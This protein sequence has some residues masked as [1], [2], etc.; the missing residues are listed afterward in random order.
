[1]NIFTLQF[2]KKRANNLFLSLS[3]EDSLEDCSDPNSHLNIN[4][5]PGQDLDT[6][7]TLDL[8]VTTD[9]NQ[10]KNTEPAPSSIYSPSNTHGTTPSLDQNTLNEC[11][12]KKP[13][14]GKPPSGRG[15]GTLVKKSTYTSNPSNPTR[16][17]HF[18][19]QLFTSIHL[20]LVLQPTH[21]TIVLQP[22]HLTLVL[23]LI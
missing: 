23:Q 15:P 13:P 22:T 1:M 14:G 7:P 9:S 6:D 18:A 21:L 12:P 2:G 11:N 17:V 8:N 19:I 5:V 10:T 20:T 3:E 4:T 16:Q